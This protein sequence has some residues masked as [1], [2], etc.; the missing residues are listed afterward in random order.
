MKIEIIRDIKDL[1]GNVL[2]AEGATLDEET[3]GD[4]AARGRRL[5]QNMECFLK[6]GHI[7]SDLQ[8][9]LDTEPYDFIFGGP[10]SIAKHLDLIGEVPIPHLF[11]QVIDKFREQD[12]YTYRHSLIVFALT[13]F[14]LKIGRTDLPYDKNLLLIGPTHDLGKL[15][16]PLE[17]LN[18]KTVLTK[19]ERR[20]L[21]FHPIA[22]YVLASYFL[23]DHRHPAAQIALKHHERRDGSGYPRKLP[24]VDPIVEMVAICDVYDALISSRPYRVGN[25]DNRAALDELTELALSGAMNKVYVQALIGRNREGHPDSAHIE[26][27][28]QKRGMHPEVNSYGKTKSGK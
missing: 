28:S 11:L 12:F 7:R 3:M 19:E 14:M 23:G 15:C 26:L 8:R 25:Y 18:K 22:G 17:I 20:I 21:E 13:T 5:E 27:T 1:E 16:I 2:I 9:F 6:H 24:E 4:I 10:G